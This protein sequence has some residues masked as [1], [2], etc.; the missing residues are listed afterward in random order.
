MAYLPHTAE[1]RREML[2]SLGLGRLE[3]LFPG[4]PE[5]LRLRRDLKLPPRRS[6]PEILAEFEHLAARQS[7]I[8]DRPSFLGA[9][10]YRRF[11]P[12]AIDYLA[13]RGEFNTAYTP[14]QPEVSQGTLQAIFEYQSLICRLTGMEISNASL[15]E[16]GTALAESVFMAHAVRN[17]AT[18]VLVSE[19]VHPEYRRVLSTY[20]RSHPLELVT[21]PLENCV[22]PWR[23]V[24][25]EIDK[26]GASAVAAVVLQTPN[27]FGCIEDAPAFGK[28]LA[29]LPEEGRPLLIAVVDPVSLG[30]LAAPGS[31]GADVAVGDGQGLGN[32]PAYGGPTF[33]FF[34]TR[35]S[36]VR[37]VPGRIVGETKD[38]DGRR[39]YVLTFQTREQ[40]IRRERATSNI[41]TNQGLL[42]LR[43]AMYLSF[44]GETGLRQV[45]E[46][47]ARRARH[48]FEQLTKIPG[49]ETLTPG[50]FFCEFPLRLPAP[51]EEVYDELGRRGVIGG[52]PLGR[53]FPDRSREMLFA[54]TE[55]TTAGAIAKLE[56][57][58]RAILSTRGNSRSR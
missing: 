10:S 17:G 4:I 50:P 51:A 48:A 7:R 35:M 11:V 20:V 16:A 22:T 23:R 56:T 29:P 47:C 49:V 52:F 27:F 8:D 5:E 18:K 9:G 54:C 42:S 6:E 46:S 3:D 26:A 1:D 15:Y 37:K 45:A 44:L 57:E 33:G 19:G 30:V 12:A 55:L 28:G 14:Y 43:G 36:H 25:E 31:Y 13:S 2:K 41:C 38:R 40:H 53:V 58:L 32:Y 24:A 39:G 34:T 21:L